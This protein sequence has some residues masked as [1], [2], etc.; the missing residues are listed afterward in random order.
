MAVLAGRVELQ[1]VDGI[2]VVDS[3]LNAQLREA[4]FTSTH[5]GLVA[6]SG[7]G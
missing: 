1:K 2:P 4:G 5:R 3:P 7:R 6:Y